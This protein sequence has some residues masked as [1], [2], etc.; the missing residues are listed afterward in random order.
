MI[1]WSRIVGFQWD[2]GN[3]HKSRIKHRVGQNEAEEIFFRE[4]LVIA[5]DARH[6]E[7][8]VRFHALGAT[9]EGRRLHVTFTLREGGARIRIISAR[10]MNQKERNVYAKA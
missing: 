10:D 3:S 6:S 2:D 4:P 5:G 1:D 7:T 8:E 9:S